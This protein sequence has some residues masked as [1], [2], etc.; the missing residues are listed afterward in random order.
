M[1]GVLLVSHPPAVRR[2]LYGRLSVERDIA[3]IGEAADT[4]SAV[5]LAQELQPE[6]VLLDAETPGLEVRAAVHA[7]RE[8]CPS[9]ATVILSHNTA[10]VSQALSTER[11]IIVGRHEGT[12]ALPWAIRS[13]AR[14]RV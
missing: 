14:H 10:A 1:I 6:V 2:T 13:A 9:T 3:I 12:V 7:L 8:L 4:Q 5:S 11:S